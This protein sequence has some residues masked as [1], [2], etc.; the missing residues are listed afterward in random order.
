[1]AN[2][3]TFKNMPFGSHLYKQLRH[4]CAE[5]KIALFV[6]SGLF[7]L[8]VLNHTLDGVFI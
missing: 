4:K 2:I 8:H 1:M 5:M 3:W 6:L 7:P